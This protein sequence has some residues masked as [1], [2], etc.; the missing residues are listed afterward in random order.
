MFYIT[1]IIHFSLVEIMCAFNY[2]SLLLVYKKIKFKGM[3][4]LFLKKM[5]IYKNIQV[6]AFVKK[7][8]NLLSINIFK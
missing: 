1:S 2:I 3:K 7:E 5:K 4:I 6:T 8:Q